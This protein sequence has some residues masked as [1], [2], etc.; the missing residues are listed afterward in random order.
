RGRMDRRALTAA[1]RDVVRRHEILRTGYRQQASEPIQVVLEP[2]T[3]P[4][5]RF[6]DTRP[7]DL[8]A[9]LAAEAAQPFDIEAAPPLRATLHTLDDADH[10]VHIVIH[11]IAIDGWAEDT[12]WRDLSEAYERHRFSTA[13]DRPPLPVQDA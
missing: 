6:R 7:E 10:V 11:H 5:L 9:V 12:L 13:A 3:E 1:L 4:P 2:P 8:D